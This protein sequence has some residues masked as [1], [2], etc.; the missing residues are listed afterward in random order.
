MWPRGVRDLDVLLGG[1]L[2]PGTLTLLAGRTM[3]GTSTL[4]LS[5]ARYNALRDRP[6]VVADLQHTLAET[7]RMFLAAS[8]NLGEGPADAGRLAH[9]AE[10]MR[11]LPLRLVG[12]G[13]DVI[14]RLRGEAVR[15]ARL[16]LLDDLALAAG[17]LAPPEPGAVAAELAR[18]ARELAVPVVAT[19]H[20]GPEQGVGPRASD[21][22]DPHALDHAAASVLLERPARLGGHPGQPD[23]VTLHVTGPRAPAAQLS[24][25]TRNIVV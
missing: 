11:R 10:R 1:G 17:S 6:V 15:G 2:R 24:F 7:G 21:L 23:L 14:G 20:L 13:G 9:A 8:S 25:L 19:A 22:R 5:I 12:P 16:L 4:L 3:A 18:V